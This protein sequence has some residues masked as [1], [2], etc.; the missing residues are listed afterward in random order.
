MQ[1]EISQ[2]Q[3]SVWSAS[4]V[5]TIMVIFKIF[6]VIFVELG[7]GFKMSNMVIFDFSRTII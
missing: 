3:A 6:V 4:S 2:T 7:I 1:I 5:L